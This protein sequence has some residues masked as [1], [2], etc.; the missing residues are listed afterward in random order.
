MNHRKICFISIL[1]LSA[2]IFGVHSAC[3]RNADSE[4]RE[5]SQIKKAPDILQRLARFDPTEIT[6]DP[7]LLNAEQKQVL[8][9]LV[10]A[11]SH[12]DKIFWKQASHVGWDLK[13]KLENAEDPELRN[14]LRYLLIN[15][16][17]FDR[18]DGNKPFIGTYAKPPG[19]GFYPPDLTKEEFERFIAAHPEIKDA[20]ESPFTVIRRADS[21]L[22]AVPYSEAYRENLEEVA[23]YLREAADLTSNPSLEKFLR[24]RAEDLLNNEYYE[25]DCNWIDLEDNLVEIIIGPYEVYEDGLNGLKAAY[26]SFVYINDIEEM[27]KIEGYLAYLEEIQNS[28]PV[29][30]KYKDQEVVG[31]KSP[32]NV[33]FEVFAAGDTKAGVQTLAFVLP[34]DERVREEKGTKKVF[35]KN[36]M[37]AKFNKVLVPISEKVLSE[38]DVAKVSFWAYFNDTILHELS[39]VFGVNYTTLPN[40]ERITVN[41][42][43]KDLYSAIEESK[44]DVV[45]LYSINLLMQ[46]GWIPREKEEEIYTTYLAGMFR[47]MRFGVNEAH[48]LGTLMQFN[49]LREHGGVVYDGATGKFHVDMNRIQGAVKLLA[50]HLL[51]LEG[52]GD[53]DKAAAFIRKYGAVDEGTRKILESLSEIPVDIAPIFTTAR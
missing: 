13:T 15:F 36:M 25:S 26:E 43:L 2:A 39:H 48:G 17:P 33:V 18:L 5:M 51:T 49:F 41:R 34:N 22:V 44:A 11:S 23:R 6:Y 10:L 7:G 53:Y 24:Q 16:G 9:K 37:E 45:G 27:K 29:D 28:L 50:R 14:Y 21:D 52:E 4:K 40:G 38:N 30:R 32:L 42:A 8:E 35:L 3:N 19:A 12:I 31:L 20:F 47:S 46:K 1:L